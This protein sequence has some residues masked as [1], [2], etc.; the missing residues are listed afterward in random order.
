MNHDTGTKS[1][2]SRMGL[3]NRLCE[4]LDE[5]FDHHKVMHMEYGQNILLDGN[6]SLAARWKKLDV[7]KSDVVLMTKF[8]P[9][10]LLCASDDGPIFLL[11]AKS[12]ITPIFFDSRVKFLAEESGISDIDR[13]RIGEIEREAWDNYRNRFPKKK[14][15]ICFA[16]PYSPQLIHVE[17]ASDLEELYRFKLD[18]NVDAGGS[19]TP[20]VN[21]DLARTR[22]MEQF[23]R[24][25]F[26]ISLDSEMINDLLDEVKAWGLNK[27]PRVNWTQFN[28]VIITLSV[29]CPWLRGRV[30]LDG[31]YDRIRNQLNLHGVD[32]DEF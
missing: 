15:A 19:R 23:F 17:W 7:K 13:H 32:F 8:S 14:V 9:D 11:D 31:K 25:E 6:G 4:L 30:P 20:H 28:N 22:T 12:S 5:I 21:I 18:T 1:H 16:A 29:K 3:T 24:D 27:P 2:L 26:S 10:Y